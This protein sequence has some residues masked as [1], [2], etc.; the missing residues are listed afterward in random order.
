MLS[1]AAGATTVTNTLGNYTFTGLA[2]GTYTVTPTD[3]GYT[4]SPVNQ[5][6]TIIG[7][8]LA[9]VNFTAMAQRAH[10]VALSWNASSSTVSGYNVYRSTVSGTGYTKINSSLDSALAYTDATVQNG[11]TYYYVTTAL[12]SSGNESLYSNETQA[13]IP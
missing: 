5:R 13:I 6:V 7:T 2:N 9:N 11:T 12:D 8:N 3:T 10:S 4:F 1:G